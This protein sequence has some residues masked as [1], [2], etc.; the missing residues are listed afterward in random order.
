MQRVVWGFAH[1]YFG[2][3]ADVKKP[4]HVDEAL[5]C[6]QRAHCGCRM[7]RER[8]IRPTKSRLFNPLLAIQR[9]A[10]ADGDPLRGNFFRH[11]AGQIDMQQAVSEGCAS[12]FHIFSQRETQAERLGDQPLV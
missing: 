12:H 4:R 6:G 8:L 2:F 5:D 1:N 10:L 7:R 11:V 3:L 9:R